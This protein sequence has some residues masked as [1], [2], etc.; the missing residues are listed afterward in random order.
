MDKDIGIYHLLTCCC[1]V[2]SSGLAEEWKPGGRWWGGLAQ[3]AQPHRARSS[4]SDLSLSPA[5]AASL[6]LSGC[7]HLGLS[8][9]IAKSKHYSLARKPTICRL[10][11][12][13]FERFRRARCRRKRPE[14]QSTSHS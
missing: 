9:E 14:R 10:E 7:S 3:S 6:A 2:S 1:L 11:Q 8:E 12:Q 4:G 5:A 13:F